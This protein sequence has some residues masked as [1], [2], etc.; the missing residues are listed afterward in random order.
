MKKKSAED[1]LDKLLNSVNDQKAR[2]RDAESKN[3]RHYDNY[4]F[5]A[6]TYLFPFVT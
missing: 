2:K 6:H 3:Y 4:K 5:V 1:Y